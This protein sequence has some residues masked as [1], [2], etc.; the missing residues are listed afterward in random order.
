[1][2]K[3]LLMGSLAASAMAVPLA[4]VA[5]ADPLPNPNPPPVPNANGQNPADPNPAAVPQANGLGLVNPATPA[6]TGSNGQGPTCVVSANTPAQGTSPTVNNPVQGA[7][8]A[9]W[10]QVATLEGSVASDLGLP[11]APGQTMKVFCAP[12]GS[13][14]LA[15]QPTGLENPGQTNPVQNPVQNQ[16][17]ETGLQNPV[18]GQ[19]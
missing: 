15:E 1:M 6:I 4:G 2:L 16:P 11:P 5:W 10:L 19:Q 3:K 14:N 7:P 9:T 13:Q 18:P 12:V 17:G 8:G